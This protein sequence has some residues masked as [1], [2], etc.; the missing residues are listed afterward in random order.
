MGTVLNLLGFW[1]HTGTLQPIATLLCYEWSRG[2]VSAL[3]K[4][5]EGEKER[6]E[7]RRKERR[8]EGRVWGDIVVVI[9]RVPAD[10]HVKVFSNV[11]PIFR[12]K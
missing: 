8:K 2:S 11:K 4:R 12:A 5:K 7:G 9:V 3:E 1:S 6:R 10:T